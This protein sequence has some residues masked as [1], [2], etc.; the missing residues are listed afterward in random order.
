MQLAAQQ[1]IARVTNGSGKYNASRDRE[2]A[3]SDIQQKMASS[4]TTNRESFCRRRV[5][6]CE[7]KLVQHNRL[8][9]SYIPTSGIVHPIV[10]FHCPLPTHTRAVCLCTHTWIPTQFCQTLGRIRINFPFTRSSFLHQSLGNG[11]GT[12]AMN[13]RWATFFW[14]NLAADFDAW[15]T[16]F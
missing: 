14:Q 4:R 1:R 11:T 12:R 15:V 16:V 8:C 9:D 5:K 3:P 10:I 2:A 13:K 7:T 6:C